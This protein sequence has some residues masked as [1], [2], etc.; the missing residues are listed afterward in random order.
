MYVNMYMYMY[1]VCVSK[2]MIIIYLFSL[3]S[4]KKFM[5]FQN[6]IRKQNN[7]NKKCEILMEY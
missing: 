1:G 2:C 4:K 6:D 3:L 7:N 5:Y